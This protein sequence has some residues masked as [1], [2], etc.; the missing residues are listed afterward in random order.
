MRTPDIGDKEMYICK[1]C[2]K[3]FFAIK[4]FFL[5][6]VKCPECGCRNIKKD[7]AIVY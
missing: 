1:D 6:F 2:G 5:F 7:K 3:H 4:Q